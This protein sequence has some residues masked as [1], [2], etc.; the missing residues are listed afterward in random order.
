MKGKW[1]HSKAGDD[2]QLFIQCSY[3]VAHWKINMFKPV[4]V[5][6][7]RI[8]NVGRCKGYYYLVSSKGRRNS[9]S[10]Q[11]HM[12]VGMKQGLGYSTTVIWN[13]GSGAV[14]RLWKLQQRGLTMEINNRCNNNKRLPHGEFLGQIVW[15]GLRP[16]R[17]YSNFSHTVWKE[18][19]WLWTKQEQKLNMNI[20]QPRFWKHCYWWNR[21]YW[22]RMSHC[23][24]QVLCGIV[25]FLEIISGV[26][27]RNKDMLYYMQNLVH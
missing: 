1:V 18:R 27:C 23:P 11:I 15:T 17:G 24:L 6:I 20:K 19:R 5:C 10:F 2:Y 7:W 8:N 25:F 12:N 26:S 4:S 16:F 14:H 21:F 22:N 9:C 3:S 13:E